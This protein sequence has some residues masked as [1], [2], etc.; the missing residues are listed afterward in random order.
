MNA[1]LPFFTIGRGPA[2]VVLL[3][4]PR[5][6][7]PS[8]LTRWST[9]RLV[10][11]LARERTVHVVGRP[12]GLPAHMTMAE[13]AEVYATGLRSMFDR[14]IDVLAVST[15]ASIALQLAADHPGAIDRLVIGAG[16]CVLGPIGR[17]AQREYVRR[18]DAGLRPS[19]ALA[20]VVSDSRVARTVLRPLLWLADGTGDH[21]ESAMVL[22]AEDGFDLRERMGE[23]TA[24]TLIVSGDRDVVY[25]IDIARQTA[26]GIP[27]G[28]LVV[29]DGVRHDRVVTDKRFVRD[30][31]RFLH[32]TGSRSRN[33]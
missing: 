4:L 31:L 16:G 29:Y 6:G 2:L 23:I 14:P 10:A 22:N 1:D 21:A 27:A 15:G 30:A 33:P 3:Y 7:N 8:G 17:R 28:H 9:V 11:P 18:A 26:A 25:P 24:P 32:G 20:D 12:A 5:P 19:P 13:L